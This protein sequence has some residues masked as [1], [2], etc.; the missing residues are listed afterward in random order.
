MNTILRGFIRICKKHGFTLAEALIVSVMAGYCIL[1]ILGTMQNVSNR[2]ESFDHQSKMA[3]Y[4]R[5]RLNSEIANASFDHRNINTSP[6]YHYIVYFDKNGNADKAQKTEITDTAV[7]PDDLKSVDVDS[8]AT[9]SEAALN[10]FGLTG[11]STAYL[12]IAHAYET[13]VEVKDSPL[14]ATDTENVEGLA[15]PN[16][17]LS[18]VASTHLIESDGLSYDD[19]GYCIIGN[20]ADG[21]NILDTSINVPPVSY[22]ALANLPTVSDEF[23]WLV[24]AYNIKLIAVDPVSRS[25]ASTI[26]YNTMGF[27]LNQSNNIKHKSNNELRPWHIAIHPNGKLMAVQT[28][29]SVWLVN[30]DKKNASA[31]GKAKRGFANCTDNSFYCLNEDKNIDLVINKSK[32]DGGLSFRPDGK[33]LFVTHIDKKELRALKVTCSV[34]PSTRK[35]EWNEDISAE[36]KLEQESSVSLNDEAIVGV[37]ASNDGYLYVAY[38]K[39]DKGIERYPMYLNGSWTGWKGEKIHW[40]KPAGPA[41]SASGYPK[42]SEGIDISPDGSKIV[43][44]MVDNEFCIYD[45][46]SGRLVNQRTNS[47]SPT[48]PT[49]PTPSAP[50]APPAPSV[51]ISLGAFV[52]NSSESTDATGSGS[53][54][55]YASNKDDNASATYN[56]AV[57]DKN[58]SLLNEATIAEEK[59]KADRIIASPINGEA[60]L[61]DKQKPNLFGVPDGFK[62]EFGTTNDSCSDLVANARDV[63]AVSHNRQI[64]L[65]D[66]NTMRKLEDYEFNAPDTPTSLSMNPLGDVITG[67]YGSNRKGYT[68]FYLKDYSVQDENSDS[69]IKSAVYDDRIPNM[70]FAL[71]D[72]ADLTRTECIQNLDSKLE[73]WTE[74]DYFRRDSFDLTTDWK[75]YDIIGMPN[76]GYMALFGKSDGSSMIEWIGRKPYFD[77]DDDQKGR[78]SLFARWASVKSSEIILP[79]AY[80]INDTDTNVDGDECGI[81]IETGEKLPEGG[82]VKSISVRSGNFTGGTRYC[83]PL[84]LKRLT[85]ASD[86]DYQIVDY[87]TTSIDLTANRTKERVVLSWKNGGVV[88]PDCYM[89]FWNGNITGSSGSGCKGAV[90][91]SYCQQSYT[92]YSDAYISKSTTSI[93]TSASDIKAL[94]IVH[95]YDNVHGSNWNY[96]RKYAIKFHFEMSS[97]TGFPPYYAKKIAVSPD[98]GNIAVLT[99]ET[100]NTYSAEDE[101]KKP[102]LLLYDFN[103]N[104]FLYETQVPGMI[105]DYREPFQSGIWD[106]SG[107]GG[108]GSWRTPGHEPLY[109]WPDENVDY[110]KKVP[111]ELVFGYTTGNY[112][113]N[114]ISST[115][116]YWT[117]FNQ[118]PANYF[119]TASD[120]GSLSGSTLGIRANANKRFF[121]YVRPE[122]DVE[123]L[124]SYG[125]DDRRFF[126]NQKLKDGMFELGSVNFWNN[127]KNL[128][129]NAYDTGLFQFDVCSNGGSAHMSLFLGCATSTDNLSSS[130]IQEAQSSVV[131]NNYK[132]KSS[133]VNK[134]WHPLTATET[135]IMNYYPLLMETHD[136]KTSGT[137]PVYLDV[138]NATM[139]FSR[140]KSY[141]YIFILDVKNKCFWGLGLNS[142]KSYKLVK[143]NLNIGKVNKNCFAISPDGQRL[144]VGA[145][146]KE[147]RFYNIGMPNGAMFDSDVKDVS[148]SATNYLGYM[149]ALQV[150]EEPKAI[151]VKP[152]S[153]YSRTPTGGEY[154]EVVSPLLPGIDIKT[155]ESVAVASGGIYLFTSDAKNLYR[156]ILC[157]ND[158]NVISNALKEK[159]TWSP[160]TAYDNKL[161]VFGNDGSSG[162]PS[163][164]IQCYD[165]NTGEAMK[166]L[167]EPVAAEPRPDGEFWCNVTCLDEHTWGGE[168]NGWENVV[169]VNAGETDSRSQYSSEYVFDCR[170]DYAW[171]TGSIEGTLSKAWVSIKMKNNKTFIA[172]KAVINNK[173]SADQSFGV[174]GLDIYGIKTDGNVV[175]L[176]NTSVPLGSTNTSV[177]FNLE[178][179]AY[180]GYKFKA[181]GNH[182]PT[183]NKE[184]A[185]VEI[186]LYRTGAKLLTPDRSKDNQNYDRNEA[187]WNTSDGTITLHW[188]K[189]DDSYT[190]AEMYQNYPNYYNTQNYGGEGGN[191]KCWKC[192]R[193]SG[194]TSPKRWLKWSFPNAVAASVVRYCNQREDVRIK[195]FS[196]YG[197]NDDTIVD[198]DCN[199][200]TAKWTLLT[201]DSSDLSCDTTFLTFEFSNTTKYKHYLFYV[202]S[203]AN[204]SD[205][206]MTGF[207]LY[208]TG[209]GGGTSVSMTENCLT[210]MQTDSRAPV[211]AGA[212]YVIPTPYG[213]VYTGGHVGGEEEDYATST[214]LLYW[215]QAVDKYDGTYYK[216]GICRSLPKLNQKRFY[217]SMVWHKGKTYVCGG[218]KTKSHSLVEKEN[219]FERLDGTKL[220]QGK[221]AEWTKVPVA[222]YSLSYL[223]DSEK[224]ELD[225]LKRFWHG[226]CSFGDEIFI[227]G[228]QAGQ[229]GPPLATCFAWNPE[230][231]RLRKLTDIKDGGLSPCCAVVYGS[232]IYLIGKNEAGATKC[233]SYTP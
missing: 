24:D 150:G 204:E 215:P 142:S 92:F 189:H 229:Y 86:G 170:T 124:Q 206:Q 231:G 30:I 155:N 228:G 96:H 82:V 218:A 172:N 144:L 112:S 49:P 21:S 207:E 59:V 101:E 66:M 130:D 187:Y 168:N 129:I 157:K 55:L 108:I 34:N 85:P 16:G 176:K 97:N 167:P 65:Y 121:G 213:L 224:F 113:L 139:L 227:F 3:V 219:F 126:L 104:N 209:G 43:S 184:F 13:K 38:K 178:D 169:E 220:Y 146:D 188:S 163:N 18:I 123:Y 147:I 161:Y 135:F 78:Y 137:T 71:K 177:D 221:K 171:K 29:K 195:S 102:R 19:D 6:S 10:L 4:T 117:S 95:M 158:I 225:D 151:A 153:S 217:H 105:V 162:D 44:M 131:G 31:Y 70:V 106:P 91:F 148:N 230:T 83:T 128:S 194:T 110:F 109:N 180:C 191:G 143:F 212:G 166:S 133:G 41:Y 46:R 196:L 60:V 175:L 165:V 80:G 36:P 159:S 181:T 90:A 98:L 199:N 186:K 119:F 103:N 7:M 89:G 173:L 35:L 61:I 145:D 58:T 122:R 62:L 9:P 53:L 202:D 118:Y 203:V 17:L 75:R 208:S 233:Y 64:T 201:S 140:D 63:L 47:T 200:K 20:N 57:G 134:G 26:D 28:Q 84:I 40:H 211:N 14:L 73:Y 214:A 223:S 182:H 22:F 141:P 120:M 226:C 45:T 56:Y 88:G 197:S 125:A 156:W 111:E 185:I 77:D 179:V 50:P 132:L 174:S 81:A 72:P 210:G 93:T 222:S 2:A 54:L 100:K 99:G 190:P 15:S 37:K 69:E 160:I 116:D 27:G 154:T 115:Y 68:K 48:P 1:P 39:M 164:R 23:I 87:T 114:S 152:Y 8:D 51:E 192:N 107:N 183:N 127:R 5:S 33:Y 149:G 11:G 136:A 94:N 193:R 42:D 52:A 79:S 12:R 138:D 205:F 74:Y 32:E 216:Y 76:G 67:T 232:K 198:N 25:I